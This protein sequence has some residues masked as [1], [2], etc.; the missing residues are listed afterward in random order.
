LASN[1]HSGY[2]VWK[3]WAELVAN[4]RSMT[5]WIEEAV[6]RDKAKI[7]NPWEIKSQNG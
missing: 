4:P 7:V 6:A 2:A 5:S 1:Y 3:T